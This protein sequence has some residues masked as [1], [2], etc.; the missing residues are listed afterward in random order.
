[1]QG[2]RR[3]GDCQGHDVVKQRVRF[4]E[5]K[6]RRHAG[7]PKSGWMLLGEQVDNATME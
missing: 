3:K 5:H 6:I 4:T 1:M 7:E 2:L